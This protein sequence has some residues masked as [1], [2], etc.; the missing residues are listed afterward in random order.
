M[1][2]L[3]AFGIAVLAGAALLLD[4]YA[5]T[6]NPAPAGNARVELPPPV[7]AEAARSLSGET[8]GAP[9]VALNPRG[10]AEQVSREGRGSAAGEALG[11]ISPVF[12]AGQ[13]SPG[14]YGLAADSP[15]EIRPGRVAAP[16]APVPSDAQGDADA[17]NSEALVPLAF[18]PLPPALAA[19][20]PRLADALRGLQQDF[21]D[22]VGPSQNP[23][24]PAYYQRWV[25]AQAA[26][27]ERFRLLVGNEDFLLEQMAVNN[28]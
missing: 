15:P 23:N 5:L 18:R 11:G 27:D 22:A 20:N 2:P 8:S 12:A 1:R 26:I 24:D 16:I 10:S 14:T 19:A 13:S 6:G 17:A 4:L 3:A 25:A 7:A 9:N 21:V 28:R